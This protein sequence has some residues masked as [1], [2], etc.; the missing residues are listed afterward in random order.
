MP[1]M[2]EVPT[3]I[4]ACHPCKKRYD[5]DAYNDEKKDDKNQSTHEHSLL[6]ANYAD[7]PRPMQHDV[8]NHQE[9]KHRSQHE[10]HITPLMTRQVK[11]DK[12]TTSRW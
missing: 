1:S 7:D 6:S 8:N 12:T 2:P 11:D 9:S 3:L 10:M 5:G 4:T